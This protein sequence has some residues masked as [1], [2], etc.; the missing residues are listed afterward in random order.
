MN[1]YQ[2]RKNKLVYLPRRLTLFLEMK[3]LRHNIT[4]EGFTY[5]RE[6][7]INEMSHEINM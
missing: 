7:R 4:I 5:T 2:Y 1:N 3:K 6:H